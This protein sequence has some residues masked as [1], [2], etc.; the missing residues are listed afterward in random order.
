MEV[1]VNE[2][3]IFCADFHEVPGKYDDLHCHYRPIPKEQS[4]AGRLIAKAGSAS[5]T[6]GTQN[7]KEKFDIALHEAV[8]IY[9]L[10]KFPPFNIHW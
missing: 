2:K 7:S 8:A 6:V 4:T 1:R 3:V 9:S 5:S 10:L